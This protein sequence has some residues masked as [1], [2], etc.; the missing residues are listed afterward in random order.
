MRGTV[1][2]LLDRVV[3]LRDGAKVPVKKHWN[4]LP[5]DEKH[6]FAENIRKVKAATKSGKE[7]KIEV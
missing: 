1:K 3:I 4:S 5:H 2:K 6:A 7:I